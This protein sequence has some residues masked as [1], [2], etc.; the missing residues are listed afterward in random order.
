MTQNITFAIIYLFPCF[1]LN[2]TALGPP[3]LQLLVITRLISDK[4]RRSLMIRMLGGLYL[5]VW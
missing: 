3:N 5:H 2:I 4:D 1:N